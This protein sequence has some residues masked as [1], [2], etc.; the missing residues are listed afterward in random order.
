MRRVLMMKP[1]C[2]NPFTFQIDEI[3]KYIYQSRS[4]QLSQATTDYGIALLLINHVAQLYWPQSWLPT[5]AQ[6][7]NF[8]DISDMYKHSGNICCSD[9]HNANNGFRIFDAAYTKMAVCSLPIITFLLSQCRDGYTCNMTTTL[10]CVSV[11]YRQGV[12]T[13][14]SIIPGHIMKIYDSTYCQTIQNDKM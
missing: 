4:A 3:K 5:A 11:A 7:S 2:L 6:F 13:K 9:W 14:I 12:N 8:D 10:P 1:Y